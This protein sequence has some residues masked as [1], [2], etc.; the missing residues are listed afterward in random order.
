MIIALEIHI[1]APFVINVVFVCPLSKLQ[2]FLLKTLKHFTHYS[3]HNKHFLLSTILC[4]VV[5]SLCNLKLRTLKN[6]TLSMASSCS[7]SESTTQNKPAY[8][9]KERT[10]AL[11]EWELKIQTANPVDFES[12][13]YHGCDI[14]GYYEAQGLMSYFDMLNG[15]IY[16]TLVK[17]F[18]VRASVYDKTASEIEEKDKILID[19]TL[20]GKTRE[21]MG[22]DPF[23][24]TEIRSSIMGIPVFILEWAIAHVLRRDASGKY[25]RLEIPNP[26]SSPWNDIVNMSL[27][28]SKTPEKYVD[29]SIEKKLLLKIQNENLLPK[30]GGSDQ[31][32]LGH[33]VFLHHFINQEKVNVPKYI[34][35][36]LIKE[37][38]ESQ[39]KNMC[40]VPYGRLIS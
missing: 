1:R 12:L 38:R 22:L 2:T 35:K 6:S 3:L 26:K 9:I 33:R 37:L 10:M 32:S 11:E 31:P 23:S 36:H 28:N 19:P 39:L 17:H 4:K 29:L 13:A 40:W 8:E 34:F 14:K 24:C 5:Q 15:P 7:V 25:S 20:E 30:G 21:E 18:W 27:F 16:K